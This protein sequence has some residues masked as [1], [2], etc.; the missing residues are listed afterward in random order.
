MSGPRFATG[1]DATVDASDWNAD[2]QGLQCVLSV[3]PLPYVIGG[4]ELTI[5]GPGVY[6]AI[7]ADW[8][9]LVQA[10]RDAGADV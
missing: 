7:R 6:C 5:T 2:V 1:L 9:R 3:D 10:L 4:V 8:P